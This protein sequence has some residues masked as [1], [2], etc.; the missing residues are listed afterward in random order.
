MVTGQH[1]AVSYL[2]PIVEDRQAD[3]VHE[4]LAP[5]SPD[6]GRPVR[7][8]RR[9][10]ASLLQYEEEHGGGCAFPDGVAFLAP[11]SDHE[12][13]SPDAAWFVGKVDSL[14]IVAGA[15]QFA[16]EIRGGNDYGPAAEG[17]IA[18]KVAEYFA[19]GAV[20]VWDVD[21][22]GPEVITVHRSAAPDNPIRY[23]LGQVADAEPAVPGWRFPVD[24]LFA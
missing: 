16:V 17:V 21:L 5:P 4:E 12:A 3:Q 2:Y 15:P 18:V 11:C 20:V 9:V 10:F 14:Q 24:R 7:A 13:F 19:A 23:R 6:G 8:G 22:R 1:A